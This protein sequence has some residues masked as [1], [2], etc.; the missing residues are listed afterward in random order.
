MSVA[1]F[2]MW[3]PR[4]ET[5][6]DSKPLRPYQQQAV[7]SA[8]AKLA[9]NPSTLVVMPTGTGKTRTASEIVRRWS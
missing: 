4:V 6:L 8:R 2:D 3:A 7:E 9:D 1:Q 5:P